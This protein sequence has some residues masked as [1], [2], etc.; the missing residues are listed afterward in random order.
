MPP[1]NALFLCVSISYSPGWT[2]GKFAIDTP[3]KMVIF[4][5]TVIR[6]LNNWLAELCGWLLSV[7]VVFLCF[8]II[9]REIKEPIQGVAEMAVF[10]MISA[11]YLGLAH[12][13]QLDK[14]VQVTAILSRMPT[15][16]QGVLRMI[17]GIIKTVIVAVLIWAAATN[18]IYTYIKHVAISGTVPLKLWPVKLIILLGLIVYWF[19]V[20]VN[21]SLS[22]KDYRSGD[23]Q[24]TG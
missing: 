2:L 5:R 7:M 24:G 14:H 13:E 8:D 23:P 21:L 3:K 17:N 6:K 4:M 22:F 12:C 10:V 11:I 18:L 9:S 19:Q 15:R 20:I 1:Q 16:V